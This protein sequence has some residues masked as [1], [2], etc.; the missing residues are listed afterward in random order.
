MTR[1]G[2]S[3]PGRPMFCPV[4]P[5]VLTFLRTP[6]AP[7]FFVLTTITSSSLTSGCFKVSI[8]KVSSVHLMSHFLELDFKSLILR[9]WDTLLDFILS[10]VPQIYLLWLCLPPD[11]CHV[12]FCNKVLL[13]VQFYVT[14]HTMKTCN[15]Q[16]E[17]GILCWLC[18]KG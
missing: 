5:I 7:L 16:W 4:D 11:A 18:L 2:S 8:P 13:I 14:F 1:Q 9:T 10:L 12:L 15:A 17:N 6:A 3:Q